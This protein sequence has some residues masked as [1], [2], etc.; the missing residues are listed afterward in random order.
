MMDV[1]DG[2][3]L[4]LHR[5]ATASGVGFALNEVP[6]AKGATL[7]EAL[8]G[9]EDYELLVAVGDPAALLEAFAASGLRPPI[10]IGVCVAEVAS[11]SLRGEPLP[12]SGYQH[13]V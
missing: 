7:A 8:G 9:G 4:D 10:R 12:P 5:M 11:R 3:G 13:R 1:S 2:L 6:V